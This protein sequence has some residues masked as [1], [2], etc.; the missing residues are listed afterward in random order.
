MADLQIMHKMRE[1]I[2]AYDEYVELL[3]ESEKSLLGLAYVLGYR[4]PHNL[5]ERGEK[6][7]TRIA[8][9]KDEIP[10]PRS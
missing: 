8:S 10:K 5:V 1:L 7:R 6:L 2:G 9:L 4:T 3:A